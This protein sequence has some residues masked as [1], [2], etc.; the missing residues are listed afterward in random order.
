MFYIHGPTTE[1]SRASVINENTTR[2]FVKSPRDR[3]WGLGDR[4]CGETVEKRRNRT[5]VEIG[6]QPEDQGRCG[7]QGF[8]FLNEIYE[9]PFR[10]FEAIFRSR[11]QSEPAAFQIR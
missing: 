5:C 3:T 9:A 2:I 6:V 1:V 8:C 7:S 4:S 11:Y 10:P